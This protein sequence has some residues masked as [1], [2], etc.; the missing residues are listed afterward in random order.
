MGH[1]GQGRLRR[2]IKKTREIRFDS[3]YKVYY[4]ETETDDGFYYVKIN[5]EIY[6]A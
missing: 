5:V 1:H 6:I 2:N 4:L 3:F